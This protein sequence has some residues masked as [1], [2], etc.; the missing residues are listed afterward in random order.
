MSSPEPISARSLPPLPSSVSLPS[1]PRSVS[2]PLAPAIVSSPV[3]PSSVRAIAW[4][5]RLA[6]E[7]VSLPSRP[8]TAS[9]S[10][11][12]WCWIA[13][14]VV[15]PDT[16]TPVASP[17]TSIVSLR[18]GAVDDD[19]VGR[20]VAGDAAE[21]AGEVGVD[22]ADI[23]AG[24]VVDG[25]RVGA[26]ERV[27]VDRLDAVGVHRDGTGVAEEP[28]PVSVG[29][30]VD[31][32]C[33]GGAVE[34]HRVVAGL[35]FDGVAAIA[36]IPHERV[37]ARA[38]CA[39]SLPPLPS[40]VSLPSPPRSF[41]T[42]VPP[43]RL[44]FPSPPSSVVGMLSVKT[45]LLSSMRTRSSPARPSTTIFA[46]N[47]RLTLK[48]AEPSSP[49]SIW[50]MSGRPAF[51]RSAIRS[52]ARRALDDQRSVLPFGGANTTWRC[53]YEL[54][55]PCGTGRRRQARP[56]S[57]LRRRLRPPWPL[58]CPQAAPRECRLGRSRFFICP[59]PCA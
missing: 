37:V 48:S 38:H 42:P 33:R 43:A 1:P 18:L 28:Q 32:L 39:R 59:S 25:D 31:V 45:P 55:R 50:R 2:T 56:R 35:A 44:S 21:C 22:G 5:A 8:L 13:T 47:L 54:L 36:R 40:I 27:E 29:R 11:G 6:A 15:R 17:L 10:V 57:R 9:A 23:G 26:A 52:L 46:T 41:S 14:R 49:A 12:S 16:A 58:P 51:R 20:V 30:E 7:I 4:A 24:E 19:A 53:R 3:P 34:D